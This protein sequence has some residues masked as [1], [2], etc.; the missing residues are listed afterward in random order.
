V[1]KGSKTEREIIRSITTPTSSRTEPVKGGREPV[2]SEYQAA[3][4][5]ARKNRIKGKRN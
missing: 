4:D 2:G 3:G 1:V 5:E